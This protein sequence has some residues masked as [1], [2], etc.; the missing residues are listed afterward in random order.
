MSETNN[1]Q[2]TADE[3]KHREN[4]S[5]HEILGNSVT[6][7]MDKIGL[8]EFP[9]I[10]QLTNLIRET[11]T[12]EF[13]MLIFRLSQSLRED[14]EHGNFCADYLDEWIESNMGTLITVFND[15][16]NSD[17]SK[18][19]ADI[20]LT[21]VDSWPAGDLSELSKKIQTTRTR[22]LVVEFFPNT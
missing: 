5:S 22:R 12:Q 2:F 7:D 4:A 16:I 19:I 20:L 18:T 1:T 11:D 17:K 15:R 8:K 14:G 13:S 3:V 10:D 6:T 9:N 21:V